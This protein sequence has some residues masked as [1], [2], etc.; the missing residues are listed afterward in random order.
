MLE[1]RPCPSCQRHVA[2]EA[3]CPF[4]EAA[5][6]PVPPRGSVHGRLSRAAVFAGATLVGGCW[7][8]AP[9]T[10][11]VETHG[12]GS[13]EA[14]IGVTA[15]TGA[16]EGRVTELG[17]GATVVGIEVDLTASDRATRR[18]STDGSGHYVFVGLPPGECDIAVHRSNNPRESPVE[19]SAIVV[20]G[21]VVRADATVDPPRSNPSNI[22]M[23]YGAPP[24][25]RRV[26]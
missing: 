7:T 9:A 19:V 6:T 21:K 13:T 1:L 3:T 25:R 2:D 10:T 24:S 12:S 14:S 17:T 4:C 8:T 22:P 18:T 23:P 26:V 5:L 11:P 20:T 15:T 16:I